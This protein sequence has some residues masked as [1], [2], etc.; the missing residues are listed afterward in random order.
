MIGAIWRGRLLLAALAL[1][2]GLALAETRIEAGGGVAAETITNSPI[3]I[4]NRDPEEIKRL[5]D[6]LDRSEGD[7]RAAEQ[8]A[9][10]LA[11]QL[12]LTNVSAQTVVGFLRV[13]ARQPDLTL[14]Q[15]PAKMAEI[16]AKYL[17]MQERL[18][19]LSPQDP[20][21]ADLA[22]QAQEA[23]KA[24]RFDEAD[25]LLEQA[26][27]RETIA[28]DEH[29]RKAAEL[30]A[31]RGDNAAMSFD[32]WTPT[33]PD[34][35]KSPRTSFPRAYRR[36]RPIISLAGDEWQTYGS[37]ASAS[38]DYQASLAIADPSGQGRPGQC[39]SANA[40]CRLPITRSAMCSVHGVTSPA[41]LTS[42]RASPAVCSTVWP[43]RE[44]GQC[45]VA[46]RSLGRTQRDR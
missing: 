21:A 20:T 46:A 14:D 44:P 5:A 7:L 18:G 39:E 38:P 11:R 36:K 3:T 19:S 27:A 25:R 26:E 45:G 43:K 22:R 28:V 30:R 17:Q 8:E 4:C 6:Q 34:T 23:A 9:A 32:Y 31:A 13:L 33:R 16:T 15:V 29:R 41:A 42:Y 10:E 37:L 24:G 12:D 1:G 35:T 40:I 2:L